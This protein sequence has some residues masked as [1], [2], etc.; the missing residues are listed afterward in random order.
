MIQNIL[1]EYIE[2]NQ[3]IV[4]SKELNKI[5]ISFKKF[6]ITI[7]SQTKSNVTIVITVLY[8]SKIPLPNACIT[9]IINLRFTLY[10]SF[11]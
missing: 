1:S 6:Q 4:N 8:K 10:R 5:L 11:L 7:L 9:E 3:I 2:S